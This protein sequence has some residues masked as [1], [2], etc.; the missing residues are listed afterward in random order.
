MGKEILVAVDESDHAAK[1]L[2]FAVENFPD[3]SIT[4]LHVI[5]TADI[6]RATGIE[7]GAIVNYEELRKGQE[8]RAEELL[9]TIAAKANESGLDIATD[10]LIGHVAKSIVSYADTHDSDQIV[11]GS[12]GRTGAKRLLLGSVAE[13]VARR[14]EIP[15]TIVR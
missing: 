2:D 14:A 11:I 4:A 10:H 15:V 6:Y 12:R 8:K 9:E 5:D 13:N 1:A 7:D 3:A